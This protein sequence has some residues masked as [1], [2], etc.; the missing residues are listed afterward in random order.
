MKKLIFVAFAVL[1]MAFA[2]CNSTKVSETRDL[3]YEAYCDS[4][5]DANPDYYI[6]VLEESDE[7]IRYVE[8]NGEWW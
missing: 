6:D 5:W 2:G 3:E 1:G 8:L 7:Y 4:I